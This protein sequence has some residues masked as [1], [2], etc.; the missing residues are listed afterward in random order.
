M[1]VN[2]Y[3]NLVKPKIVWLLNM[4]NYIHYYAIDFARHSLRINREG[5]WPT[6]TF[7]HASMQ[8]ST[9]LAHY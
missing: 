3:T 4:E 5:G 6:T 8:S 7:R 2:F 9:T 1:L